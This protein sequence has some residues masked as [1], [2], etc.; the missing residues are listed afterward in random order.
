MRVLLTGATG[1]VGGQ[2]M[3]R[4]LETGHEVLAPVRAASEHDAAAR[5]E[6][7][8]DALSVPAALRAGARTLP[9]DLCEPELGLSVPARREVLATVD[10]LVHCAASVSFAMTIAEARAVNV[11]ATAGTTR[12]ARA[13]HERGRL[14]RAVHVSTAYVAGT[15]AGVF[16]EDDR[17]VGQKFRNAYEQ[18]KLE[19][20]LLLAERAADLPLTVVRPSI[21]VGESDSGWTSAFNVLYWP[22]RALARGLLP[23]VPAQAEGLIDMVPV[24]YVADGIVHALLRPT[25]VAGT[26]HLVAGAAAPAVAE[27]LA[28]SCAALQQPVPPLADGASDLVQRSAD[29]GRY[30]PYLDV[31][32]VFDDA[33]AVEVLGPAGLAAPRWDSYFDRIVAYAQEARWGKAPM[34]RARARE[35]RRLHVA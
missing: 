11:T 18:S 26:L 1:F 9:G 24:D 10:A 5:L 7:A 25:H 31:Q 35:R 23:T 15:H 3:L 33:R 21:V 4:L 32:T 29:A 30:V 13:L 17:Y 6:S 12:L 34:P 14:V 16:R 2:V 19:S 27:V 28:A 8:L 22:L 20:E